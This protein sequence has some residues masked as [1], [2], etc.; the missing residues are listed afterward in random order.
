MWAY[1]LYGLPHKSL[2]L[3]ECGR[4]FSSSR[5]IVGVGARLG[6]GPKQA[7]ARLGLGLGSSRH[8]A[9]LGL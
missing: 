4:C 3:A 6:M 9:P 5:G 2:M 7:G 8:G 1:H